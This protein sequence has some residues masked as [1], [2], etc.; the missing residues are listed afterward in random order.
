MYVCG[1]LCTIYGCVLFTYMHH[2]S[3]YIVGMCALI[4][5]MYAYTVCVYVCTY[6][7]MYRRTVQYICTRN[8]SNVI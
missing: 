4:L 2:Y 5:C 7:C 1:P 6:V 3:K 8:F